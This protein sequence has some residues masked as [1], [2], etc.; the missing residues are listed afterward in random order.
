MK[1]IRILLLG[2]LVSALNTQSAEPLKALLITGGC[3]H[4]Y[5]R[6]KLLLMDG[7]G[8][9]T[10]VDWTVVHE[11]GTGTHHIYPLLQKKNWSRDFDIV[12]YNMCFAKT[13]SRFEQ[14][15]NFTI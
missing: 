5:N 11:G 4:D 10:P 1:F 13:T 15:R 12:V 2:L 6:Q 14:G 7:I 3:C 9:R 8:R